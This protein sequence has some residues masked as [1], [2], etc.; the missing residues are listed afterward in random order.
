[1]RWARF[2][3][4]RTTQDHIN[5]VGETTMSITKHR[6]TIALAGISAVMLVSCGS[7]KSSTT[8]ATTAAG[9]VTTAAGATTAAP[10]TT[11]A[12]PATT[13]AGAAATTVAAA[14]GMDKLVADCKK[15]GKVNLIA[16]PDDWANYKGI[17]EA[18]RTKYAGV[19]NPVASPDISSQ[20]ELDAIKSPSSRARTIRFPRR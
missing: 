18:F 13:A 3:L 2:R 15:E 7:S 5:D 6:R 9:A 8:A 4:V 14:G 1:M 10:A 11:A 16:L 12:A 17:L 20:E 19:Q